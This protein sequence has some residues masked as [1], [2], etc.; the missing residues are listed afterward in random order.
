MVVRLNYASHAE[1]RILPT[2]LCRIETRNLANNL[3]AK[4]SAFG[5]LS[6][7]SSA[8]QNT[9]AGSSR[10]S[11]QPSSAHQLRPNLIA[12]LRCMSSRRPS[13]MP[14]RT[15]RRD[16]CMFGRAT[17]PRTISRNCRRRNTPRA[18][19]GAVSPQPAAQTA[20]APTPAAPA[21]TPS[22]NS[23]RRPWGGARN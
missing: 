9:R 13:A 6:R 5:R 22:A 18:E 20:G 15:P 16:T 7:S 19:A 3:P 2:E 17:V 8:E 1:I 11:P 10:S 21:V 23:R 12:V 4:P 14:R